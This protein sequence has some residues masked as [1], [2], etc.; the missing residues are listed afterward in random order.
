M[1]WKAAPGASAS[2]PAP[3]EN[4]TWPGQLSGR[5]S[6]PHASQ[7]AGRDRL[8]AGA[9]G[10]DPL[11]GKRPAGA[12]RTEL[13]GAVQRICALGESPLRAE[14]RRP[15]AEIHAR[16]TDTAPRA[17]C[18]GQTARAGR[19]FASAAARSRPRS[20]KR[21]GVAGK[22]PCPGHQR[23]PRPGVHV[24]AGRGLAGRRRGRRADPARDHPRPQPHRAGLRGPRGPGPGHPQPALH[25]RHHQTL[26]R[27]RAAKN[28]YD[29]DRSSCSRRTPAWPR[30]ARWSAK[31][32][33]RARARSASAA[34]PRPMPI[35]WSCR[36]LR[37]AKKISGRGR[38]S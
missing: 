13:R 38:S 3:R 33:S 16:P 4:A 1:P 32:A 9:G 36:L 23:Q 19:D 12:I 26:G 34:W 10:I 14:H 5:N 29:V 21:P 37:L 17:H 2:S 8:R 24:G 30:T 7:T 18:V 15:R 28:V 11:F 27:F 20:V 25:Q 22:S 6:H 31:T 35:R